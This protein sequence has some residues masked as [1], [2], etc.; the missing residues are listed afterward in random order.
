MEQ[1]IFIVTGHYGSGKTE[2]AVNFALRL[3]EKFPRVALSDLDIVNPY[4]RSRE[5]E[6]LLKERGVELI[7]SSSRM[8]NADLPALPAQVLS[9]FEDETLV[10]V[11]DVGGDAVGA[12]VLARFVPYAERQNYALYMVLNFNRGLTK[13]PEAA[14]QYLKS[15]EASSGLKVTG[16]VNNTHLCGESTARDV[17]RGNALSLKVAGQTGLPLLYN[18]FDAR[19]SGEIP[20]TLAGENFPLTLYMKKPWE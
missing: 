4:F 6:A 7:A 3:R 20:E 16:L 14:V 17:L 8:G 9:I 11:I 19:L 1:R 18:A 13:T 5:R 15:I 10:G 12:R 2:F